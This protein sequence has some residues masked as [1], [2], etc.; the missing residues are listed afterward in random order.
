MEEIT[1]S[2]HF[3]RQKKGEVGDLR[4]QPPKLIG[5][6]VGNIRTITIRNRRKRIWAKTLVQVWYSK[7]VNRNDQA[8]EQR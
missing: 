8:E 5:S 2:K 4:E 1:L 3:L 6:E 7:N